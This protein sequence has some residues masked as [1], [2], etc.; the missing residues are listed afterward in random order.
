MLRSHSPV[1]RAQSRP[2]LRLHALPKRIVFETASM[3]WYTAFSQITIFAMV[4]R[5]EVFLAAMIGSKRQK[6]TRD[7][8]IYG[9]VGL[10]THQ[11]ECPSQHSDDILF[12]HA[13][14]SW[15]E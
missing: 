6:A 4:I 10:F 1:V 3:N 11:F 7:E 8:N 5:I 13:D 12:H 2:S 14:I 9:R 15:Q